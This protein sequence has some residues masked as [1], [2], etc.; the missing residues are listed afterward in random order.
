MGIV[1]PTKVV[2]S[3]LEN[4]VSGAGMLL[5]TESVVSELPKK[6]SNPTMPGGMP[7]GMPGMS[8]Y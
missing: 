1:D 3:A 7:G 6:E 4:A 8:G 5:T 2:R